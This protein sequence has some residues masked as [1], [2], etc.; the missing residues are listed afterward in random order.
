MSE[1]TCGDD[2][3]ASMSTPG[4]AEL[5]I[6]RRFAPTRWLTR[7]TNER[8]EAERRQTHSPCPARKRRAGRATDKAACAAPPL[9]G[10]LACRRSTTALAAATERHRSTPVTRF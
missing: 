9:S 6:G 5:V 8:K 4:F 1:A 10:A 7:A 2:Q 3:E